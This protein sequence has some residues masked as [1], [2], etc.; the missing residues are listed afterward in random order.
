MSILQDIISLHKPKDPIP[1][2]EGR[3]K[4]V[5]FRYGRKTNKEE[6]LENVVILNVGTTGKR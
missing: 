1:V 4:G 3:V 2:S 6:M 5:R